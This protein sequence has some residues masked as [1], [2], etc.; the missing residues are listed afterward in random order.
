MDRRTLFTFAAAVLPGLLSM[1][2]QAAGDLA[3]D[4]NK[5]LAESGS[6]ALP[7]GVFQASSI[8]IDRPFSLSGVPGQTIVKGSQRGLLQLSGPG[9][10]ISGITFMGPDTASDNDAPLVSALNCSDLSLTQCVFQ[11]GDTALKLQACGGS[12]RANSF[13]GQRTTAVFANDSTGM[14]VAENTISEIGNNGILVWRG[15][16][17]EDGTQIVH[18]RISAISDRLG[19]TGENGNGINVYRAGSVLVSGNRITDCAF[20]GIRNNSGSN[21]QIIGNSISRTG[22]VALY[23]EFGFEGAI[24]SNNLLDTVALGI[25]ITNFDQGGR[26]AVCTGNIVRNVTGGSSRGNT[27]GVAIHAESDTVVSGNVVEKAVVRGISLGWGSKCRNLSATENIVRDCSVAIAAS[28]TSGAGSMLIESN[29]IEN[30]EAGV[31][32]FDHEKPVTGELTKQGVDVPGNLSVR[33]N[34]VM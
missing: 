14:L 2:A 13:S 1:P 30:C 11:G 18:N 4:I 25:S 8:S 5:A 26:L 23:V 20:T 28:V 32:G 22:E 29:I 15:E 16:L 31:V 17:G 21:C 3:T 7:R 24:V 10:S 12:V 27:Q 34:I 19:G 33:A 9:I 6:L